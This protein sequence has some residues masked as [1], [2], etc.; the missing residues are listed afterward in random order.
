[1]FQKTKISDR[2]LKQQSM[3]LAHKHQDNGHSVAFIRA[4]CG[5]SVKGQH[6]YQEN[7]KTSPQIYE[8][9]LSL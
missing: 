4:A 7:P 5:H 9:W 1:M 2:I 8:K 3:T 6:E